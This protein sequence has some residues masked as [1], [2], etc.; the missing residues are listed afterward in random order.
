MQKFKFA[1]AVVFAAFLLTLGVFAAE[2]VYLD[3]TG[4]I[5]GSYPT[6]VEAAA[7]VDDGGTVVLTGDY[8]TPTTAI[9][10]LPAK[11]LTITAE[12]DAEL[13]LSRALKLGGD[14]TFTNIKLNNGMSSNYFVYACGHTLIM[15][16]GVTTGANGSGTY[17]AIIVGANTGSTNGGNIVLRSGTF[18]T[19]YAG[20]YNTTMT[21][22]VSVL[23]DGATL[24]NALWAGNVQNTGSNTATV[25]FTVAAG[26]VA[27][28][29]TQYFNGNASL[30]LTGGSVSDSR[31]TTLIDL[32]AGDS[33]TLGACSGTLTTHAPYGYVV[34]VDGNVYTAVPKP[35]EETVYLDATGTTPGSYPTLAEAADAVANGGTVILT[36]DYAT[37]SS[38]ILTLPERSFTVTAENGAELTL[39]RALKLGGDVTF[40]D[41]QINNGMSSNYFIYACGHTLT[42][43]SGVTTGANGSGG[44]IILFAGANNG[45]TD[46]GNIILRSGTFRTV[47]AGAYNT[48]MTGNVSV[49]L[50]GATLTN[51]LW[52]GNAQNAGSNTATVS[53]TVASGSVPTVLTQYFNGTVSFTMTGGTVT[54]SRIDTLIDLAAGQS[55]TLGN[56][57]GTLTT[58]APAGYEVTVDGNVYT[59]TAIVEETVEIGFVNAEA[60]ID[61]SGKG[62]IRTVAAATVSGGANI[63]GYGTYFIP[64]A[65]FTGDGDALT[66][67]VRVYTEGALCDGESFSA[68]L[69]RIPPEFTN[70]PVLAIAF[71]I[72]GG[73]EVTT[74]QYTCSVNELIG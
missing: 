16:S 42:M 12:N 32:T 8:S 54:E 33:A 26:S 3:P 40:T 73:E 39:S 31:M 41:I 14:T 58:N 70:E 48:T 52:A 46:G 23:L 30:T 28:V 20:T 21:G 49:L 71:C 18:R 17:L 63:T 11:A 68:D 37:P 36:S 35:L 13:T 19:V 51:A 7:A 4:E 1:A 53:F 9:L 38:A 34:T 62:N 6:L 45:S 47:Y 43:D 25:D 50:D 5:S 56:C 67:A 69:L 27:T 64:F 2:T 57:T 59:A 44:Y 24:T 15:D 74:A 66:R 72:V 29:L 65:V 10:T 61:G 60:V 22:S 55:A